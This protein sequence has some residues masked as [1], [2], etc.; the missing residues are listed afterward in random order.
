MQPRARNGRS[1]RSFNDP[2]DGDYTHDSRGVQPEK[3][4]RDVLLKLS[5]ASHETNQLEATGLKT[6]CSISASTTS[7]GI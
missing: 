4:I 3:W 6:P 2:A 1:Q 5:I 7:R